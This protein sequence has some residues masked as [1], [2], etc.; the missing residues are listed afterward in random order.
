MSHI[1]HLTSSSMRLLIVAATQAEIEPSLI[2]LNL[3]EGENKRKDHKIFVL[4]TGVGM[5]A[6]AFSLGQHLAGNDYDLALNLGIAGTF[7]RALK[8]GEVV[9]I[10]HDRFAELGA[11]DGEGFL[12]I[13]E[14]GFGKQN[15]ESNYS[16]F[17]LETLKNVIGIT[18]NKV[19]GN[20]VSIANIVQ[21]FNS[22]TE[23]MEGAA[24]FYAC[25]QVGLPC[26]Q[27]RAISNY[28]ERRNRD[29]WDIGLAVK[30][31][32]IFTV[33]FINSILIG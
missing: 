1:P 4:I 17:Q 31:L 22:Q 12:T 16:T 15:V 21:L 20:D 5:V 19:H 23:S 3:T 2:E 32:N 6:T 30:N 9:N 28:V 27:V 7:D 24:F 10:T 26:A 8:P 18:V 33:D 14:L 11:E 29:S 13:D 25:N